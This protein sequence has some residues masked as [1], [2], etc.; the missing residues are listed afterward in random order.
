MENVIEIKKNRIKDAWRWLKGLLFHRRE[1]NN[2]IAMFHC[3][4]CGINFEAKRQET[5]VEYP[6][7]YRLPTVITYFPMK[8]PICGNWATT[9]KNYWYMGQLHTEKPDMIL[10]T[11]QKQ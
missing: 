10:T 11:H 2:D 9:P 5:R 6:K 3:S 1:E 4:D 8:C 7:D